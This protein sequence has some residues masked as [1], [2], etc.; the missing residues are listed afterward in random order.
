MQFKTKSEEGLTPKKT[1]FNWNNIMV[2]IMFVVVMAIFSVWLGGRFFSLTNIINIAKQT[3]MISVMAV[4]MTFVIASGNIDLSIGS[5]EALIGLIVA[6][7]L[8]RTNNVI[9]SI[10]VGLA[11]GAAIGLT[12]AFLVTVAR[13]PSFLATLGMFSMLKGLAM[14]ATDIRTIP[15][16]NNTFTYIFGLGQIGRIPTLFVW[17]IIALFV[18]HFVLNN[19]PFGKKVLA[20]GGN[21]T[22]AKFTG[23][24]IKW[25]TTI[26]L[27]FMGIA[28]SISSMLYIG[29][30]EAARYTYGEGDELTVIAAVILGGTSLSG[31]VGNVIGAVVG[32]LLMGMINNGLI[33]GGLEVPEQMIAKGAII[34]L[35]VGLGALSNKR[36]VG[37]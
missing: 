10:F 1:Q 22:A 9:I 33:I 30:F 35:A 14:R 27:M 26:V 32:A 16:L 24:N 3:A 28:A 29:R 19:V 21:P 15:V 12:N 34:V 7:V 4:G 11:I 31:G 17:T 20:I 37:D 5:A 23:I 8:Q 6:V 18:G 36:R 25:T 13:I 2:Y